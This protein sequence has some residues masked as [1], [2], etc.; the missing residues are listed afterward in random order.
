MKTF[1]SRLAISISVTLGII[2]LFAL[3]IFRIGTDI[4]DNSLAIFKLNQ[5]LNSRSATLSEVTRLKSAAA[6]IPPLLEKLRRALPNEDG[7]ISLSNDI[8][9]TARHYGLGYG[10]KFGA[11]TSVSAGL[12]S[13][14]FDMNLQGSYNDIMKFLGDLESNGRFITLNNIDIGQQ[15]DKY[16]AVLNGL[17]YYN[18]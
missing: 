4:E 7:L 13:I 3:A 6:E 17:I 15:G 12:K 2:L 9:L 18:G 10:F 1:W 5:D 8:N 16:S 14:A 11:A